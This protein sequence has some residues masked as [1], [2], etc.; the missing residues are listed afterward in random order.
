MMV[1]SIDVKFRTYEYIIKS[2]PSNLDI[3]KNV[4]LNFTLL[5]EEY[6]QVVE[7]R[8]LLIKIGA[9]KSLINTEDTEIICQNGLIVRF[10]G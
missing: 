8:E 10:N 1:Q 6:Y 3:L 2:I 9:F 7:N 4:R 5:P